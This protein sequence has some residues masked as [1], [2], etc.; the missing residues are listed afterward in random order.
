M[1]TYWGVPLRFLAHWWHD[2]PV[3]HLQLVPRVTFSAADSQLPLYLLRQVSLWLTHN[4]LGFQ[5]PWQQFS[6]QSWSDLQNN[7][8]Q[9]SCNM[10]GCLSSRQLGARRRTRSRARRKSVRQLVLLRFITELSGTKLT[11]ITLHWFYLTATT[12]NETFTDVQQIVLI[13]VKIQ[14]RGRDGI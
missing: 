2:D 12:R 7:A 1:L 4:P 8:H 10:L 11:S 3:N 13:C 9:R 14:E 6:M 5:F